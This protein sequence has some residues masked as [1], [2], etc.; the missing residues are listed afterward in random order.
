MHRTKRADAASKLKEALQD[1]S[2]RPKPDVTGAVQH[3]MAALECLA[4]DLLGEPNATLGQVIE[5]LDLPSPID[6]AVRKM[7]GFASNQGRHV[8][9]GKRPDFPEAMLTVHFC[10]ALISYL[11][12]RK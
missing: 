8:A 9:E 12:Q 5:R 1:I 4:K 2:R 11:L 6:E 7:W 10:A 3:G